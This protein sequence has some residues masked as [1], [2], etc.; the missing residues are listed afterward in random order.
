MI[1]P[2][3]GKKMTKDHIHTFCTHCG[4]LDDGKQIHGYTEEQ[5]SD[6]EIYLGKDFDKIWRNENWFTSLILGPF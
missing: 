3:C 2:K 6:L 1:C 4:Y 5:A